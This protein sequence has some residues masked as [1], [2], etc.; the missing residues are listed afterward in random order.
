MGAEKSGA[1]LL[2]GRKGG[3]I[4]R[5]RAEEERFAEARMGPCC[6]G[7]CGLP[8]PFCRARKTVAITWGADPRGRWAWPQATLGAWFFYKEGRVG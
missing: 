2:Q 3:K 6:H 7:F 5:F 8:P 1:T 4:C